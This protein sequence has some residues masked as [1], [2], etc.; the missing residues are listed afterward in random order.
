MWLLKILAQSCD[1]RAGFDRASMIGEWRYPGGLSLQLIVQVVDDFRQAARNAMDAGFDGIE[2]HAA[3][4]SICLH[5]L[6]DNRLLLG[7]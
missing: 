7:S 4:V 1:L 3:N 2:L 5:K 6:G